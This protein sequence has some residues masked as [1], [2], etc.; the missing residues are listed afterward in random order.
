MDRGALYMTRQSWKQWNPLPPRNSLMSIDFNFLI[1]FCMN[2]QF[3]HKRSANRNDIVCLLCP[4]S[5][6]VGTWFLFRSFPFVLISATAIADYH[7]SIDIGRCRHTCNGWLKSQRNHH[8]RANFTPPIYVAWCKCCG[9]CTAPSWNHHDSPSPL[10]SVS[11]RP[12]LALPECGSRITAHRCLC[13]V[14]TSVLHGGVNKTRGAVAFCAFS[15]SLQ[16][17]TFSLWIR[18][19]RL[20]L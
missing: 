9:L 2:Y 8:P 11:H 1:I 20:W 15:F 14:V 16:R 4:R 6:C 7:P 13:P 3:V 18:T 10:W 5:I 12:H 17:T 19:R